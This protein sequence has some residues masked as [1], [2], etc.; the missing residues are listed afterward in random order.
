M[1]YSYYTPLYRT[2][3]ESEVLYDYVVQRFCDA[4]QAQA[5]SIR[6]GSYYYT[7]DKKN[8]KILYLNHL[9]ISNEEC[10]YSFENVTAC[11]VIGEPKESAEIK[12]EHRYEYRHDPMP[13]ALKPDWRRI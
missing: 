3:P 12:Y 13:P 4:F 1:K 5:H 8:S 2:K 9:S 10:E 11:F 7:R 6:L